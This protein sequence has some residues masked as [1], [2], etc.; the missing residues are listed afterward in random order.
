LESA[1][2]MEIDRLDGNQNAAN[3][4]SQ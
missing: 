3:R 1:I 4:A 2:V